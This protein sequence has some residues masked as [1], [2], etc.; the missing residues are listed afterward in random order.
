M[1]RIRQ[2]QD[3]SGECGDEILEAPQIVACPDLGDV[4]SERLGAEGDWL[5]AFV[6]QQRIEPNEA[7]A[8]RLEPPGK[9]A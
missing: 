1:C 9:R 5:I 3:L 7:S 4:P 8:A 6:T 2:E